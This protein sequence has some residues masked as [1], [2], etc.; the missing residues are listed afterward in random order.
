MKAKGGKQTSRTPKHKQKKRGWDLAGEEEGE[1]QE[2]GG[3]EEE[4]GDGDGGRGR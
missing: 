4:K 2:D 1:G 3:G